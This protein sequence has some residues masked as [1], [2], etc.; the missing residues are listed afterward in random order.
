MAACRVPTCPLTC[1]KRDLG[2]GFGGSCCRIHD[3]RA[4]VFLQDQDCPPGW[5]LGSGHSGTLALQNHGPS[6][7]R[8]MWVFMTAQQPSLRPWERRSRNPRR[9]GG[10]DEFSQPSNVTEHRPRP[11][12]FRSVGD[13]VIN[14]LIS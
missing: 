13:K 11:I 10:R 7:G 1:R 14:N 4:F 6:P 12:D 8:A 5:R 9:E 2:A 3:Q